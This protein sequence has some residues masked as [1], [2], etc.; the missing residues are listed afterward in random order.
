MASAYNAR[1]D[2]GA[3]PQMKTIGVLGGMSNQ[4]T[5]EYYRLINQAVN[6]RL[7]GWNTADV[8]ISSVNFGNI[9]RFVRADAWAEAGEY[10][11][12][13]AQGLE[14]A[15]AELLI[16]VSNTMHCVAD[17]FTAGLN[18]PFLHIAD[19]TGEAI[20]AAGLKRVG[21]LGTKPVMSAAYLKGRYAER[22]GIEVIAPNEAEQT[23]V[24]RII[25]DELVRRD[26]REESRSVY[27]DIMDRL[28]E[29]G[30]EGVI[31]GCTEIFLLVSQ[32]DRPDFPIF[33]TTALHVGRAVITA[34]ENAIDRPHE[35]A[36]KGQATRIGLVLEKHMFQVS[37]AGLDH[38]PKE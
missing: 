38:Q 32:D 3:L 35:E 8:V 31:L 37:E 4:A 2:I 28:R 12:T 15:G 30:A 18:I 1:L 11:A 13:K 27:L 19:P 14:R 7:G 33:D 34:F 21:I 16:C 36:F 26:L 25:F 9:E 23:H 17:T 24:D 20:R 5:A 29:R 10:L 22:F 6:E